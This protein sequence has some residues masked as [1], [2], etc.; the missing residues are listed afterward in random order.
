LT[1]L[2]LLLELRHIQHP[3]RG[4]VPIFTKGDP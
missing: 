1:W 4:C 2:F 3:H